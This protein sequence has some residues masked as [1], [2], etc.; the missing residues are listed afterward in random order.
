[1]ALGWR[2]GP[3]EDV[4]NQTSSLGEVYAYPADAA[5]DRQRASV[6][7][8]D[9]DGPIWVT[10][11]ELTRIQWF[12]AAHHASDWATFPGQRLVGQSAETEGGVNEIPPDQIGF[13]PT[14]QLLGGPVRIYDNSI[15][16]HD[17]NRVPGM[18]EALIAFA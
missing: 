17:K 9:S 6:Q 7:H 10:L 1:V 11:D 8:E 18:L 5:L 15:L 4:G 16:T 12:P 14:E 13:V 2:D 3:F